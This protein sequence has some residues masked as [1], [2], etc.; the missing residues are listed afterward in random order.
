MHR[1]EVLVL[2]AHANGF[3][4]EVWRAVEEELLA[5]AGPE[6]LLHIV[7]VDLP[8]HGAGPPLTLAPNTQQGLAASKPDWDSLGDC[9]L[10]AVAAQQRHHRRQQPL[11]VVG[12]GHSLGGAACMLAEL[13]APGTFTRLLLFEPIIFNPTTHV[14]SPL[15]KAAG[16]RRR[17][18]DS[19]AAARASWASKPLFASW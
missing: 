2:L 11:L 19:P 10:R 7:A 17:E 4:K 1:Q 13:A 9:V 16:R 8:G 5:C 12:V 15:A 18:F 3:C 14:P 6:A